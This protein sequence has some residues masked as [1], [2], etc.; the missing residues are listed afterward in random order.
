MYY[1]G[2][3]SYYFLL[4]NNY[5]IVVDT[6]QLVVIVIQE[7]DSFSIIVYQLYPHGR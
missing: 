7:W 2:V 6:K 4:C 3:L 1:A 5:G